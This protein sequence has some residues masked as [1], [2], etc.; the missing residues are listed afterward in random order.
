MNE[1]CFNDDCKVYKKYALLYAP[2]HKLDMEL[3]QL[4]LNED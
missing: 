2:R 1:K 3:M 4:E